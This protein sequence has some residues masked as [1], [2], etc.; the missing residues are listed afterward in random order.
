MSIDVALEE[1]RTRRAEEAEAEAIGTWE[2]WAAM[3]A[4]R[5]FRRRRVLGWSRSKVKAWMDIAEQQA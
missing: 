5:G 3:K 4:K 2:A 1:L